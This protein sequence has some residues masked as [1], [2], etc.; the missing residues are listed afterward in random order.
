MIL[1]GFLIFIFLIQLSFVARFKKSVSPTIMK[2]FS[3][4]NFTNF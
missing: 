4:F 2:L 3:I 1:C